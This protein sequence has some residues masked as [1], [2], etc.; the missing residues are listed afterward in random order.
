MRGIF[1]RSAH[2]YVFEGKGYTSV[3]TLFQLTD[4]CMNSNGLKVMKAS[5]RHL[6]LLILFSFLFSTEPAIL[7][8]ILSCYLLFIF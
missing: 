4:Y 6:A 1:D 2:L 7:I 3:K 8:Q 5:T